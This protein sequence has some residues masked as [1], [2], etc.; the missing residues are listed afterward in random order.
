MRRAA[1]PRRRRGRLIKIKPGN[2]GMDEQ[3]RH[4]R[5]GFSCGLARPKCSSFPSKIQSLPDLFPSVNAI[6]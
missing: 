6:V 3:V 1:A 5:N 2:I 4:A